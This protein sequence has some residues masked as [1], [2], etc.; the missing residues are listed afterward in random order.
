VEKVR[1]EKVK[2]PAKNEKTK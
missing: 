1:K 2:L